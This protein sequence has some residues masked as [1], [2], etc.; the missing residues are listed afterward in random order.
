MQVLLDECLPRRLK[1]L[2]EDHTVVTVADA[3][4]KGKTN[5]DLL[6]LASRECDVF[7]T[8]DRHVT[9]PRGRVPSRLAI[10]V[11]LARSNR[12]EDLR[13]LVPALLRALGEIQPGEVMKVGS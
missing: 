10:I 6:A 11:L 12:F 5:G 3:G 4:W 9:A 7:V 13:P 2:L 8:V 1:S